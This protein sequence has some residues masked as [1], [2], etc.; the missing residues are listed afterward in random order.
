[1]S[2]QKKVLPPPPKKDPPPSPIGVSKL[3]DLD[4]IPEELAA[5]ALALEAANTSVIVPDG[6][7]Y[8]LLARLFRLMAITAI[9]QEH[10]DEQA[11]SSAAVDLASI[12]LADVF[13]PTHQA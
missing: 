8:S 2:E 4:L 10:M 9:L 13:K 3:I 6:E 5:V 1:M 11:M 7:N 12:G